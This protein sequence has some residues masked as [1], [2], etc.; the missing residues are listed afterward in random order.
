MLKMTEIDLELLSDT[1]MFSFIE[2]GLRG[3]ICVISKRYSKANNK[4]MSDYNPDL[5]SRYI[6]YLDANNLYGYAM[7]QYLPFGKFRW[8]NN[9][10]V[11]K[12]NVCDLDPEGEKGYIFEV[13]LRYPKALHDEHNDYPLAVER[14]TVAKSQLALNKIEL[15]R[16][17]QIKEDESTKLIPNLY[18]KKQYVCHFKLL[19]FYLSQGLELIRIHRALEFSQSPWLAKYIAFN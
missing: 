18:D 8:L 9:D 12:L 7:S 4:Y 5:P 15:L 14:L 13:D 11:E 2:K 16:R 10:E 6:A 1:A 17:Y 3:G 19:Q